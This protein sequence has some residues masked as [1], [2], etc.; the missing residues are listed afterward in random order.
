MKRSR[1]QKP[2]EIMK[3][4]KRV[5][6]L[7]I[8]SHAKRFSEIAPD[9]REYHTHTWKNTMKVYFKTE[10]TCCRTKCEW[11][12]VYNFKVENRKYPYTKNDETL[13]STKYVVRP[14]SD[15]FTS[16]K[17]ESS[18]KT[19]YQTDRN[20]HHFFTAPRQQIWFSVPCALT[21]VFPAADK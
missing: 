18:V 12:H 5:F 3:E 16:T 13:S 15:K 19:R 21:A 11:I 7:R 20:S 2:G 14:R 1:V 10:N 8:I 17:S 9:G 4:T 6:L